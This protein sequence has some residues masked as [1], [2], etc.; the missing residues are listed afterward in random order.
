MQRETS[1]VT[2]NKQSVS[3]CYVI[4][5]FLPLTWFIS[6]SPEEHVYNSLDDR[7]SVSSHK[8]LHNQNMVYDESIKS[9]HK[10]NHT[11]E[12]LHFITMF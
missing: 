9:W 1:C 7:K 11:G 3:E 5:L 10:D 12:V 8:P 6:G 4:V 2:L